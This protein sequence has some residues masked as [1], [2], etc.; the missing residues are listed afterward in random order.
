MDAALTDMD[1]ETYRLFL[2]YHLA[3]C[4]RPD[5]VGISHHTID[6]FRKD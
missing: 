1:Q 5:M 4:E 3:T 6:I 2:S